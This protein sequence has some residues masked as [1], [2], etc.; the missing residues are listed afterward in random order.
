[1]PWDWWAS[2]SPCF[3]LTW[4][5]YWGGSVL[6]LAPAAV[7]VA[8]AAARESN[9]IEATFWVRKFDAWPWCCCARVEGLGSRSW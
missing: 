7:L 9:C 3:F 6:L 5:A 8:A 4:L 2:L 1:M